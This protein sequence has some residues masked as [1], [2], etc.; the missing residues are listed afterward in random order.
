MSVTEAVI[1]KLRRLPPQQQ[2]QVLYYVESLVEGE[3]DA[4][5][6]PQVSE[7][8]PW[9]KVALSLNLDGPP[10]W[11]EKF[12][13]YLHGDLGAQEICAHLTKGKSMRNVLRLSSACLLLSMCCVARVSA[14]TLVFA[15]GRTLTG[16][17]V[18]TNGDDLLVM[19]DYGTFNF[20]RANIKEIRTEQVEIVE[21]QN[22]NRLPPFKVLLPLLAK[23][24][25]S[26]DLRQIP[27]TVI[28]KGM[29]R[30]VPYVS[31]RCGG[32]YEVNIYGDLN[33][34]AGIEAG[35]YRKLL[36]DGSA[37]ANCVQFV[38][39]LLGQ[40]ADK[41]FARALNAEKDLKVRDG[42]T[43]EITPPSAEDAYLGWWI[44]IYSEKE[45]NLAR[46]SDDEVKQISTAKA[47]V[48]KQALPGQ[49]SSAWSARDLKFAR[50]DATRISFTTKSGSVVTNAEVRPYVEGV[51]LIWRDHAGGGIV[52]LADLPE[53]LRSR[54]G[55]DAAKAA[56][57][58]ASE[59]ERRAQE[60]QVRAAG[61]AEYGARAAAAQARAA[62]Q[63]QATAQLWD[64]SPS[65]SGGGRVWVNGYTRSNGTYVHGHSRSR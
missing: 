41:E 12:E 55:Y 54:F 22:T 33:H 40:P 38:S 62:A 31:F 30:N 7:P 53:E 65:Y 50:P 51:S 52:K 43:F 16:T 3:S 56:A 14:D 26:T 8:H 15:T 4:G 42:L 58:D 10:D 35:V 36:E 9:T 64:S 61:T 48:A 45:L 32:D 60:A 25:W 1:Q 47:D 20:S 63:A 37:K 46:A 44:S 34:P 27:A 28:D 59:Q 19:M 24:G 11:S 18:K 21:L 5:S 13:D 29:L 2:E 57:A 6:R 17:V 23:Q 39:G 49:D